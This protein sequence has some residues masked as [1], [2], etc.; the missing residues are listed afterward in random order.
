MVCQQNHFPHHKDDCDAYA[1]VE[2]QCAAASADAAKQLA[3]TAKDEEISEIHKMILA[4]DDERFQINEGVG[5]YP[6]LSVYY[7]FILSQLLLL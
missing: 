1:D 3:I 5:G 2:R 6:H 4:K 7:P